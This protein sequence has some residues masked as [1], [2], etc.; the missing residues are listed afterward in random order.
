MECVDADGSLQDV[1]C[2]ICSFCAA[3]FL[4][5]ASQVV[6]LDV[7]R[8]RDVSGS[9]NDTSMGEVCLRV[10]CL[11]ACFTFS[12]FSQV[13]SFDV[14]LSSTARDSRSSRVCDLFP[15]GLK[16]LI[17]TCQRASSSSKNLHYLGKLEYICSH[18]HALHWLDEHLKNSL[19]RNPQFG[20]CCLKGKV[21]VDFVAHL[22]TELYEYFV[23]N[24][25][26][27][28][29]FRSH[30]RRYNKVFAFTSS[31]GPWRLDGSIFDG[32]G[33]PTYK[34]QGELYHQIGPLWPEHRRAPL[35]S[36]LYIYDPGEALRHRQNNNPQTRKKTMAFLQQTLLK[37]N[38]FVSV[39]EQAVALTRAHSLPD[40]HLKLDFLEASDR[41]RYNLPTTQHELAAIIPGD[42]DTCVDSRNIIIREKGGPLIRITVIHPLYVALHFPLLAPTG[43]SG[44]HPELRYAGSAS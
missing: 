19:A 28:V 6:S 3:L 44:W 11:C 29:E 5:S 20:S 25:E 26:D 9:D 41:R 30:I 10:A 4:M 16:L 38:P 36:Q 2:R 39:Y 12:F 21:S 33:P 34:I 43:Q 8:V 40:Y 24:D 14:D 23:G 7:D 15:R 37:C 22:P 18:C 27:A 1:R 32:R 17:L 31:G 35:Y 13:T 42:V